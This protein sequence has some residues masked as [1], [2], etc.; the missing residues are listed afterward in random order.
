MTGRMIAL[1]VLLALVVSS[2][3][4]VAVTRNEARQLF[5]ETE[6]LSRT[7]DAELEEWSRLQ[8]EQAFLADISRIENIAAEQLD[9]QPAEPINLLVVEP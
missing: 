2:A 5:R 7:R 1:L 3:I 6:T 8:L 4:G 9:M